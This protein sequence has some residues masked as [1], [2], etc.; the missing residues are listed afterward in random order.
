MVG[1]YNLLDTLL[2][3]S[4]EGKESSSEVISGLLGSLHEVHDQPILKANGVL[5]ITLDPLEHVPNLGVPEVLRKKG[6][7]LK[8]SWR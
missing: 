4:V 7:N 5:W 1:V 8:G 6:G 2:L 3:L